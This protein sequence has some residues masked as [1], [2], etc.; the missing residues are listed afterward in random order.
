MAP[1]PIIELHISNIHRREAIYH[2]SLVSTVA[3]AVIAGLGAAGYPLADHR[4]QAA[5]GGLM[6]PPAE[7]L[8]S[9][10]NSGKGK[11]L[12][13]FVRCTLYAQCMHNAYAK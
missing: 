2:K 4:P 7:W 12:R 5:A 8:G 9:R 3:T 6:R 13:G 1:G 10:M 11:G